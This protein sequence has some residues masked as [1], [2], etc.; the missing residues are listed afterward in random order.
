MVKISF[1]GDVM[2]EKQFLK[3]SKRQ[4]GSYSFYSLFEEVKHKFAQ[5]DYVVAN[6]ESVFG[7]ALTS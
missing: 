3:A 2:F 1:I 6:L 4:D 7:G 5:S